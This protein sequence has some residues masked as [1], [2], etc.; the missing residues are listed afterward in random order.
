MLDSEKAPSWKYFVQIH[1]RK[2]NF[3]EAVRTFER[4]AL[5]KKLLP[6]KFKLMEELIK[7]NEL[8]KVQK[9]LDISIR[10]AG[11][12]RTL[13]HAIYSFLSLGKTENVQKLLG[14]VQIFR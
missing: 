8:E 2:N 12:E 11:E 7:N 13:Y 6:L 3:E 1:L 4:I 14:T 9:V 5:E 10:V